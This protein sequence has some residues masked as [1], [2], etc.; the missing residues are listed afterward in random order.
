MYR[1]FIT[2]GL[3]LLFA[4][5]AFAQMSETMQLRRVESYLSDLTTIAADFTQIAPDG[6]LASGKFYLKR[7]QKMR[8][9]Y[10]PPTPILMVTRGGYLTYYDYELEQVSDIPL[11]E[12]LLG[13]FSRPQ[14]SFDAENLAIDKFSQGDNFISVSLQEADDPED[15][16]LTLEFSDNP[17]MLQNIHVTDATGQTT[18]IALNNARFG[19]TLQDELF[20]FRD[21]RIGGNKRNKRNIR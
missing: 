7:P 12:T 8:W 2:A 19:I 5:P 1:F 16:T 3:W 18:H 11:D 4:L 13:L 17:L 15:G 6:S 20:S 21:P 9:Q 10:D 14:I